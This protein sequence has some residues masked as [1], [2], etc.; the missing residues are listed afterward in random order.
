MD[1]KIAYILAFVAAAQLFIADPAKSDSLTITPNMKPT[2]EQ[3]VA[4]NAAL[5]ASMSRKMGTL[6]VMIQIPEDG[7]GGMGTI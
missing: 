4:V 3:I 5:E 6:W 1:N 7:D 2:A